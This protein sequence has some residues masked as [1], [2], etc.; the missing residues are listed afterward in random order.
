[1][2]IKHDNFAAALA[3]QIYNSFMNTIELNNVDLPLE[4]GELPVEFKIAKSFTVP[5][6]LFDDKLINNPF[7]VYLKYSP[8]LDENCKAHR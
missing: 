4:E 7:P 5:S 8:K 1:M 3:D 2:Q 6:I